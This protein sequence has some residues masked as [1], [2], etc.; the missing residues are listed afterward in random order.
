MTQLQELRTHLHRLRQRRRLARW[1]T[2]LAAL[3][4][5]VLWGL[6][7]VFLVDWTANL[8][9]SLRLASPCRLGAVLLLAAWYWA[10]PWLTQGESDLDIALLIEKQHHIDNDLVA[11]L[12]FE[13]PEPPLGDRANWKPRSSVM[14]PISAG[15]SS[16]TMVCPQPRSAVE[17]GS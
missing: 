15:N 11:A 3:A 9:T 13:S 10:W 17:R 14:L 2:G 12:E 5:A 6:V 8:G 7:A 4:L 16:S 1:S